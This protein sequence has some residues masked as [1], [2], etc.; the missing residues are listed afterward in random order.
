MLVMARFRAIESRVGIVR[1]TNTG[2]SA[3]VDPHGK[4]T[5]MINGKEVEG[6]LASRV[7]ISSTGS[8]YRIVGDLLPWLSWLFVLFSLVWMFFR[9]RLTGNSA[10]SILTR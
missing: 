2:I 3:F 4:V 7:R 8:L 5:D 1:G 9:K 10:A 6:T